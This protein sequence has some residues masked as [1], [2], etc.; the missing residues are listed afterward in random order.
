M[1]SFPSSSSC[2]LCTSASSFFKSCDFQASIVRISGTMS[3]RAHFCP[4][5]SSESLPLTIA[6]SASE[7]ENLSSTDN[8]K[9]KDWKSKGSPQLNRWSRARTIRSGRRLERQVQEKVEISGNGITSIPNRYDEYEGSE[10]EYDE[11]LSAGKAIYMVSDGTGW[12]AEHSVNAALGQFEHCLVDRG[13]AVN[14]HLFSGIDEVDRLME[15]IRQAAKEEALLLYTLADPNMAEAAKKGCQLWGVP[16]TDILGPTTE[17]IATHL[18]VAPLGVPRGSPSRKTPLSKHY[19]KRIE[20]VEFTIKQDDG[21]LPQN[22]RKADI[23][24]VGVSRTSK[25]PLSTYLAQKGYKV[26]NVPLVLE[27]DPPK[28]L[29][30]IDQDKIYALIISPVIL[31]SIR[32]ARAKTLGFSDYSKSNYSEMEHIRR[33]LEYGNKLFARSPRWPVIEV[34]GKAI[35][36]IAAVILRIYHERK[37]KTEVSG[38]LMAGFGIGLGT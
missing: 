31:Q 6:S 33:E 10:D 11:E 12:T 1:M 21:A 17:A 37:Q 22:L 8:S 29:F 23:V 36:E 35:E 2:G 18:G 24:L 5:I 20:A 32:L 28:E 25:T 19:F 9:G 4:Q 27:V 30:E 26:A 16:H 13:C 34:T 15:I 38:D 3:I 14:T 7:L